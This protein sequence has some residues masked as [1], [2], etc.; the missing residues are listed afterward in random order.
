MEAL[1]GQV[2]GLEASWKHLGGILD[3]LGGSWRLLEA[4]GS[5]LDALGGILG[6]FKKLLGR[7]WRLLTKTVW[8]KTYRRTVR[9]RY[10]RR[11]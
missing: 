4:L 8:A 3:A 9:T 6:A 1:G 7:S 11:P 10:E 5:I 2:G